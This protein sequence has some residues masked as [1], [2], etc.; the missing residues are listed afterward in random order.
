MTAPV[1]RPR[2]FSSVLIGLLA[3]ALGFQWAALQL[4]AWTGMTVANA[5]SMPLGEAI[6]LAL[7]DGQ[8]CVICQF[9]QDKN[10]KQRGDQSVLPATQ[11]E[12][13]GV[14]TSRRLKLA[15]PPAR[16]FGLAEEFFIH[17]GDLSPPPSPPPQ[18]AA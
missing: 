16:V 11:V 6:E 1:Q 2:L 13:E 18:T 7:S 8:T 3:L 5:K 17:H 4:V 14:A 10:L 15:L 12:V 9:I